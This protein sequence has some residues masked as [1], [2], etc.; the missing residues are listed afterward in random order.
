M[1]IFGF[2]VPSDIFWMLLSGLSYGL[3]TVIFLAGPYRK[4]KDELMGAFLGFLAGMTL[5]HGVGG[6][7]M[8]IGSPLLMNLA[9]FGAITGSAFVLKFPLASLFSRQKKQALFFSA[10][11]I[12]YLLV[13]WMFLG[14]LDPMQSMRLA[15]IY[16]IVFSGAISAT[17]I[18][19]RGFHLKDASLKV[20]CIGGGCSI[21]SCCFFAHV[22]V[23]AVGITTLVKFFIVLAP[24]TLILSLFF[25]NMLLKKSAV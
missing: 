18:I 23:L 13:A 16:M 12:G 3:M 14:R 22:I 10:L 11:I 25:G 9:A 5:F 24:I 4:N 6:I 20:K 19:W 1:N 15:A 2:D 17:Y 21:L 7:S 8:L